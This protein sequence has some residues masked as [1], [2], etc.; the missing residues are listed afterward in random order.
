MTHIPLIP[1]SVSPHLDKIH[2]NYRISTTVAALTENQTMIT[3]TDL[4]DKYMAYDLQL[5]ETVS[6]GHGSCV[7]CVYTYI[8]YH[9]LVCSSNAYRTNS[10]FTRLFKNKDDVVVQPHCIICQ[11]ST[12]NSLACFSNFV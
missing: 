12:C 4:C 6:K 5:P 2:H 9:G 7:R 10:G 11:V 1:F 8:Q 3:I